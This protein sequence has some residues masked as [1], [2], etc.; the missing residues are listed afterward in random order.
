VRSDVDLGRVLAELER[1]PA[2][3]STL[4]LIPAWQ[5]CS[6]SLSSARMPALSVREL[7]ADGGDG[8]AV[9]LRL[10]DP[11][12]AARA[13][14]SRL[15][16]VASAS[17]PSLPAGAVAAVERARSPTCVFPATPRRPRASSLLGPGGRPLYSVSSAVICGPT[18]R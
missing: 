11:A 17:P 15:R 3:S 5:R 12:A 4:W 9:S 2:S 7:A 8:L 14:R 1:E 10:D 18:M 16:L 6:W 13:A